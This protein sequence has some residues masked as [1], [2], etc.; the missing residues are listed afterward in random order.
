MPDLLWLACLG[1]KDA[2]LHGMLD[3]AGYSA[4]SVD[5]QQHMVRLFPNDAFNPAEREV[6]TEEL[7]SNVGNYVED[8]S[9]SNNNG[10]RGN[11][12]LMMFRSSKNSCILHLRHRPLWDSM[13]HLNFF[14]SKLQVWKS[15][16]L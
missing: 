4:L 16:G 2:Y 11:W 6:F 15:A 12:V 3:M 8:G 1:I 10:G 9:N 7:E 13:L 5:L 14:A